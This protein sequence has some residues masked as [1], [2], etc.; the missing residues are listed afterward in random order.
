MLEELGIAA[1]V[2][3][4]IILAPRIMEAAVTVLARIQESIQWRS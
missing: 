4:E 2:K 1:A 3:P